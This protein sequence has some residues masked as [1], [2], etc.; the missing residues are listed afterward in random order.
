MEYFK[1]LFKNIN[2]QKYVDKHFGLNDQVLINNIKKT[3][4]DGPFIN[5]DLARLLENQLR[6]IP[7]SEEEVSKHIFIAVRAF[8]KGDRDEILRLLTDM[9]NKKRD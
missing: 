4:G 3:S 5:G 6:G 9:R 7:L 8:G 1:E 2:N